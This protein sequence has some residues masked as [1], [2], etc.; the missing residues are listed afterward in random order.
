MSLLI[1]VLRKFWAP[2]PMVVM[3][4]TAAVAGV[5]AALFPETTGE[6]EYFEFLKFNQI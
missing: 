4:T 5:T 1:Q 3:G 2:L 6:K